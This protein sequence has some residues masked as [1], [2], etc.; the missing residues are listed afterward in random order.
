MAIAYFSYM[1]NTLSL[2]FPHSQFEERFEEI[3]IEPP[4]SLPSESTFNENSPP[5][6]AREDGNRKE[7]Q[8]PGHDDDRLSPDFNFS[9]DLAGG[10]MKIIPSDVDVSLRIHS[11]FY[12]LFWFGGLSYDCYFFMSMLCISFSSAE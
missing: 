9:H 12:P 1:H 2:P 10:I 5:T 3:G 7:I 11:L 6:S 8:M 4:S